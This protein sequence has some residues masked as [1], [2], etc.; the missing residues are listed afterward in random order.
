MEARWKQSLV[1][2]RVCIVFRSTGNLCVIGMSTYV[3]RETAFGVRTKYVQTQTDCFLLPSY[4]FGISARVLAFAGRKASRSL[5]A[6]KL[7]V[8]M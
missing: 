2:N 3:D 5:D 8:C 4:E 7:R 6:F 1:S